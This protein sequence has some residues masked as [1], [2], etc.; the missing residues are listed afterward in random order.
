MDSNSFMDFTAALLTLA[1]FFV[2][3]YAVQFILKRQKA[4]ENDRSM[5]RQFIL[6]LIISVGAIAFLLALPIEPDT[7]DRIT[8]L[9]GY[10]IS[11]IVA[12]SSATFFGNMLAGILLRIINSFKAGDFVMID[13]YE[14]RVSEKSLFHTEMQTVDGNFITIP[15]LFVATHPIKV[16]RSTDTIINTTVS[17]GYDVSRI[18]IEQCLISAA[19]RAGLADPFV[20]I[21]ELGDFSVVYK[22]HGKK[23]KNKKLLDSMSRLNAMVLD[24]LHEVG[25]EIV[26]PNFMN[27][28]QVS[29]QTFIPK[30]ERAP[31][32]DLQLTQD[33][34]SLIFE[35]AEKAETIE[36]RKIR[37][38]RVEQKIKELQELI[39]K[40]SDAEKEVQKKDLE[41]FKELRERMIKSLEAKIEEFKKKE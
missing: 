32:V 12:L 16:T 21:T 39:K 3:Y 37:I 34:D 25:I 14:G 8:T 10:M 22:I 41:R 11:A 5:L 20:Y 4:G 7:K 28:R 26:S 29:D 19:E 1:I 13:Q 18:K 17:L 40:S 38:E 27:Q 36:E 15:N 2:L 35:K 24:S 33:T 6:F 30:K 31:E 9:L 23:E